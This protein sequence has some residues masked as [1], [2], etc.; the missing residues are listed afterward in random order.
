MTLQ[1]HIKDEVENRY[2]GVSTYS[3]FIDIVKFLKKQEPTD[4]QQFYSV[5]L[6]DSN[7]QEV[8]LVLRSKSQ[9]LELLR[10]MTRQGKYKDYLKLIKK[11]KKIEVDGHDTRTAKKP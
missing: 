6:F 10:F 8:V 7:T 3:V 5:S 4:I 11:V 2:L 1:L 9:I